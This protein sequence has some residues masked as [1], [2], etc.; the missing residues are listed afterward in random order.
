MKNINK[1]LVIFFLCIFFNKVTYSQAG[2]LDPTFGNNGIV[3]IDG[4]YSS[5]AASTIQKDGKILITGSGYSSLLIE[6]YNSDGSNDESFGIGGRFDF[7]YNIGS[8]YPGIVVASQLQFFKM[9]K[10]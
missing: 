7:P 1:I 10:L 2:S 6:R 3:I 8:G 5:G 4:N 9:E